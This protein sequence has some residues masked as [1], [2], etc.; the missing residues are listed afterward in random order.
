MSSVPPGAAPDRPARQH[1]RGHRARRRPA[2][3]AARRARRARPRG[4]PARTRAAARRRRR[5]ARR[6]GRARSRRA[7]PACAG[8]AGRRRARSRG[9][10]SRRRRP[11]GPSGARGPR[12]AAT[13]REARGDRVDELGLDREQEPAERRAAD[14]RELERR[15]SAARTPRT[16]ISCGTSDGVSARPAGEPSAD[17]TPVP[18]ASSEERPGLV[19]ARPRHGEEADARRRRRA[20]STSASTVRRG[21]RSARWPGGQR[22]QRERQEHR[23]PDEPEVERVA[24]DLVDLPA[25]RDE[26]HLDRERRRHRGDDVER[27]V[28]V[29]SG[30]AEARSVRPR[31]CVASASP[32][33]LSG[34]F[35]VSSAPTGPGGTR[36]RAAG[37]AS[38]SSRA[39]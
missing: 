10:A 1:D 18:N 20:R 23:E 15:P 14:H 6:T 31:E 26:R 12:R 3:R 17:A 30:E 4:R 27:E 37:C 11:R 25:D 7:A 32:S 38:R 21:Y 24:V 36:P 35:G 13:T 2:P 22:E 9:R 33:R 39:P 19:R 16:S 8:R 34:C 28:A 29:P 5:T